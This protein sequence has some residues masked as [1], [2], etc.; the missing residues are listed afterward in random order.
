[1]SDKFLIGNDVVGFEDNGRCRPVSRVTLMVDNEYA[2]TAGDDT[3]L[4]LTATC[5][6]ATQAMADALL[7][8]FK[9]YEYQM[10][11][12]EEAGLDPAAEL[13][14]GIS[15]CGVYATISRISDDG[16]GFPDV[17]GP[18][19]SE[20]EDEY[21]AA[22][23][24]TQEI[25]RQLAKTRSLISKSSE[26]IMLKVEQLD[27]ELGQTLRVA[28]DGVT[29]TNAEG[30]TLTIDGGQ[31]DA[32]KIKTEELDA[33]KINVDE[34]NLTGQ[35]TWAD[36]DGDTQT[37]VNNATTTANNASTTANNANAVANAAYQNA[38]AASSQVSAWTYPGTTMINGNSLVTGTVKA[39]YL[40][41]GTVQLL[42]SDE[43]VSG[44]MT[45]TPASTGA[46]AVE[47]A[48]YGALRL[49]SSGTS[50]AFLGAGGSSGG[51]GFVQC[52]LDGSTP[53]VLVGGA[54]L[55]PAGSG[56]VSLGSSGHMWSAVYAVSGTIQTSDLT[57]KE[58]VEELPE[59][60]LTML[61]GVTPRRFKLIEGTSGRYHVGF[62]AQEVEA[63][64]E[65]AGVSDMEFGGW[66]KDVDEHGADLYML[67]YE[68]F[69][70]LLLGKLRQLEKRL[71]A[72]E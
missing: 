60:Y 67:R 4:E 3:G 32:S 37:T 15:V 18:G 51:Y 31:I 2:Y 54:Q 61:D 5:I 27:G 41:G 59:K 42:S 63:A 28:A 52:G 1:M 71:E 57:H 64:M 70:G 21:P 8:K 35:I 49:V 55:A 12:A 9:G 72:L 56:N 45:M 39:S 7:E 25:E 58:E 13:G 48:S 40:A 30:D 66:V 6:H 26:E 20:L 11:T 24:M 34:L 10:F 23:P 62:I 44:Y 47:L 43:S 19:E 33:S 50:A 69:I 68:E 29:I 16:N 38:S 65:A 36:L 22:G 46:Y 14:D 17:T 53:S